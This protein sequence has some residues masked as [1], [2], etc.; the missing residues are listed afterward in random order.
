MY[1]LSQGAQNHEVKRIL[2][3]FLK[4][5][6]SRPSM[7]YDGS[8]AVLRNIWSLNHALSSPGLDC[9]LAETD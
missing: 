8:L 2:Y 1:Y 3:K 7:F 6:N 5:L 4:T 9:F